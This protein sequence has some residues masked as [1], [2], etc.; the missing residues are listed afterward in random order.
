[1]ADVE[2]H[3]EDVEGVLRIT[4]IHLRYWMKI[5]PGTR[6]TVQRALDSYADK[7]PAYQS[8]KACIACSWD[9]Q[10]EEG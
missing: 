8:V 6:A 7:C 3:I 5:P 1:V 4:S 9:A 2:G 10:I